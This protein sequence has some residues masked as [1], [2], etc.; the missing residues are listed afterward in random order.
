MLGPTVVLAVYICMA[1]AV[2]QDTV[3]AVGTSIL[4]GFQLPHSGQY[5]QNAARRLEYLPHNPEEVEQLLDAA[6][7]RAPANGS[8]FFETFQHY[9][10]RDCCQEKA[11][12]LLQQS[13]KRSPSSLKIY[14]EAAAYFLKIGDTDKA[15]QCFRIATMKDPGMVY[16][17]FPILVRAQLKPAQITRVIARN[18]ES[19]GVLAAYLAKLGPSQKEEWL[20]T[21]TELHTLD[22]DPKQLLVSAEQAIRLHELNLAREYAEKALLYSTTKKNAENLLQ[23]ISRLQLSAQG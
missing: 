13:L 9:Q 16:K 7:V 15:I 12:M 22:I 23:K 3:N 4:F 20:R 6:L 8:I 14:P 19:L 11:A 5:Y 17:M 2:R 21:V 1:W 18:K 10:E